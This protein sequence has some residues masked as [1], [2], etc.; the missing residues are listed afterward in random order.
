MMVKD[1]M[2]KDMM[3]K[4]VEF[5]RRHDYPSLDRVVFSLEHH[6]NFDIC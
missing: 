6:F 4:C 3:V 5:L 2:V 1:M